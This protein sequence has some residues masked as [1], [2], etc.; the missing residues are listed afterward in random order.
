MLIEEAA[1]EEI[2]NTKVPPVAAEEMEETTEMVQETTT[3]DTIKMTEEVA[4]NMSRS[5]PTKTKRV[6]NM[7][8]ET[9][10]KETT[11]VTTRMKKKRSRLKSKKLNSRKSRNR[12]RRTTSLTKELR[13]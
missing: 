5:K 11:E 9:E 2:D 3:K 12:S 8:R 6:V 1:T 10:S 7:A 4:N 13:S